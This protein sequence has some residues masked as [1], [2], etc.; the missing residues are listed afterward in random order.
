MAHTEPNLR[1][2]RTIEDMVDARMSVREI[3][4]EIGQH[5]STVRRDL[6]RNGPIDLE[7]QPVRVRHA[8]TDRVSRSDAPIASDPARRSAKGSAIR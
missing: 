4:A 8:S 3:A 2:R 1:E 5:R 7:G 6:E